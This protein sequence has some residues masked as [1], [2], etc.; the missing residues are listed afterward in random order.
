MGRSSAARRSRSFYRAAH[1]FAPPWIR[2]RPA[3]RIPPAV[4]RRSPRPAPR[5][6]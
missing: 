6:P 4:P 2:A 5:S 1:R 3:P